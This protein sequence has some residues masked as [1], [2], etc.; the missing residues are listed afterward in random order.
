MKQEF[1]NI[2]EIKEPSPNSRGQITSQGTEFWRACALLHQ[3]L[4]V[5]YMCIYTLFCV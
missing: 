3:A 2:P 4:S 1:T 5:D